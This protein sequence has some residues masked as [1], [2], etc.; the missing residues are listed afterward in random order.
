MHTNDEKKRTEE[1]MT[2][3]ASFEESEVGKESQTCGVFGITIDTLKTQPKLSRQRMR[4]KIPSKIE[5]YIGAD[6]Y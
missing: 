2:L 6:Y 1:K 5:K 4:A 3:L